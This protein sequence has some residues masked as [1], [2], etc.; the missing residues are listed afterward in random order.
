MVA[1]PR[2]PTMEELMERLSTFREKEG[3]EIYNSSVILYRQVAAGQ[4]DFKT[5]PPNVG[6]FACQIAFIVMNELNLPPE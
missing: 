5:L 6:H 4:R 1:G 2:I 3:E